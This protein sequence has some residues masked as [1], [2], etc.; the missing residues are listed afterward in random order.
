MNVRD[1]FVVA[2]FEKRR[3]RDDVFGVVIGNGAETVEFMLAG[4]FTCN[5]VS[6][7]D[8]CFLSRLAADEIYLSCTKLANLY[9][10]AKTE[11]MKIYN[12]LGMRL[13]PSV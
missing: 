9:G 2:A 11:K 5:E 10:V 12:I 13:K 7:L 3:S 6:D 4:L 1:A 8:V